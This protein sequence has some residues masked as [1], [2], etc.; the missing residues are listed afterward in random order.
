MVDQSVLEQLK[1]R[2]LLECQTKP[3]ASKNDFEIDSL[4]KYLIKRD[5]QEENEEIVKKS[6][7]ERSIM[8][9]K[10]LLQKLKR[11]NLEKKTL[12]LDEADATKSA[13]AVV[14]VMNPKTGMTVSHKFSGSANSVKTGPSNDYKEPG[15]ATHSAMNQLN[16]NGQKL[17]AKLPHAEYMFA[18][19]DPKELE[20]PDTEHGGTNAMDSAQSISHDPS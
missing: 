2:L 1:K 20:C 14:R 12:A 19:I 15:S 7:F 13:V 9:Q 8:Q 18:S 17:T 16:V 11:E 5:I 3:G 10:E 6:A 4:I